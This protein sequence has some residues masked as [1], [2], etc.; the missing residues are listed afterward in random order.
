MPLPSPPPIG[1]STG[2]MTVPRTVGRKPFQRLRPALPMDTFSWSRL[3]TWPIGRHALEVDLPHLARGQLELGAIALP[4]PA[5]C[6][7][8][9]GAAAQLRRP[10]PAAARRCASSVPSGML[11][12]GS[13]LPG[14]MSACGPGHHRVA[15]LE[16]ERRDDVALLA[17]AVVQQRDAAPSGSDRTRSPPPW[18]GCRSSRAGS[19]SSGA[20]AC[21]RR[22]VPR[23]DAARASCA[24][25]CAASA[26][27]GSS[28]ASSCVI[29]SLARRVM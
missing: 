12:I 27:A 23:R 20:C 6:A 24:R 4:W 14:R 10:C 9:A 21:A 1:W 26:R 11:R 19:R 15:D 22:P 17:V 13:A 28:P 25:R 7:W 3:P 2:F 18:P 8:R 5:S 29:S 16:A